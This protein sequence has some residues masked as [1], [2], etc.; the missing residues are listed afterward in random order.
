MEHAPTPNPPLVITASFVAEPLLPSLS[1]LLDLAGIGLHPL[2][3][4]YHQ[5]FQT[6]L[7]PGSAL[8]RADGGVNLVLIRLE[9]FARDHASASEGLDAANRAANELPA[10]L[11]TAISQTSRPLVCAVLPSSPAACARLGDG[12]EQRRTALL[13]ELRSL[14]GLTLLS[15]ADIERV[16]RGPREDDES[17]QL[18]HIPFT[19]VHFAAL[20][21]AISRRL[22]A[23]L[24]PPHKVLVLDCDNTLWRG[25][26]GEEGADGI[27][28][29]PGLLA[30]QRR[31]VELQA[32]GVL[33]ALASKNVEEDVEAVFATRQDMLLRPEHIIARRVNWCSKPSN[34]RT[35]AEELNLGLDAFVF[36]DDN[37]LECAQMRA[38][39]P[40][41]VTL[42]LPAD[43]DAVPAMLDNL[44]AFDRTTVTA[45]D[46]Q[47]TDMYRENLA[48]R[49]SEAC[50]GSFGDFIASLDIQIDLDAPSEDEWTRIS[51][52]S[53]RTNQFNFTTQRYNEAELRELGKQ[54][55]VLRV[56]VS[57]RFGDY[58]LVGVA[59]FRCNN[60]ALNVEA[61]FLS[62]RALGRGV[63]HALLCHLGQH[64]KESGLTHIRLP[65]RKTAKN[66][67]AQAF[68]D[69]VASLWRVAVDDGAHDYV[70][71]ANFAADIAYQ[72][73]NVPQAVLDALRAEEKKSGKATMNPTDASDR[74]SRYERLAC[75]LTN[76]AAVL[77]WLRQSQR[78]PRRLP[79]APVPASNEREALLLDLWT[80][81]LQIDGLGMNDDFHELG[82]TS[83]QAARL[84]AAIEKQ[85]GSRWPFSTLLTARTPQ[86]QIAKLDLDGTVD[87]GPLVTLRP[88]EGPRLFLVHD[89]DGET[90][91]Y[92]N[93][94]LRLPEDIG[95]VGIE[96]LRRQGIPLAHLRIEDMAA[97]YIQAMRT[98]QP[99]GPY[100]LAGMCA[101][102]VIAYE[103]ARQLRVAGLSVE[104]VLLLDAAAPGAVRRSG[105][106]G[107]SHLRRTLDAIAETEGT[108]IARSMAALGLIVQ[109]GWRFVHWRMA[110][111][112]EQAQRRR[113]FARLE[114]I[115]QRGLDLSRDW[116]RD[117][118]PLTVR[119]IYEEA[120]RRYR[121]GT[122]DDVPLL[123]ARAT[124][125]DGSDAPYAQVFVD[126]DF[127]W[128]RIVGAHP[129]LVDVA[130]GHA[131]M[132]QEPH[133]ES[134]ARVFRMHLESA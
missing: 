88:G 69:S 90:L 32:E 61:F 44:W 78:Q 128:G 10:A 89:G 82:G 91:L 53:Q 130:G 95:I 13:Q 47:R 123:L 72:P 87:T 119:E 129:R 11:Q 113:R 31:A 26:V 85:F 110:H 39:L 57:D 84:I 68:A 9:D 81:V 42:Q 80:E 36:V 98:L 16:S 67:P 52:L 101:G 112:W 103:M 127:G 41:V 93:L 64:A 45:E 30:L 118:Q 71:P 8:T 49:Q 124:T 107:Q 115:L 5:V 66:L 111:R 92:R 77:A 46:R 79:A 73:G 125:G 1:A 18:G 7:S 50:A 114:D 131:S 62:C 23:L 17:N 116:P 2:L 28:L 134:L 15:D 6:L 104:F 56:R 97:A 63:E 19:E 22:H 37:P 105:V 86:A 34:L 3:A 70:I 65:F 76:G 120:E 99:N 94:A 100:R 48:R 33:V 108:A 132:L 43:S 40:Q 102:G 122:L 54:G 75:E 38:A 55:G 59:T 51:Q 4:P 109:R 27:E 21:L 35:L 29:T 74:S 121:P 12:I 83:L 24:T 117:W 20:A 96:P 60:E 106:A 133:V 126:P 25:V 14:S 58:G